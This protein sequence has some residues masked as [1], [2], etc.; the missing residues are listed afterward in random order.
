MQARLQDTLR[1]KH[2][3]ELTQ[4]QMNDQLAKMQDKITRLMESH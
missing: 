4:Q 1:E 3:L 2:K